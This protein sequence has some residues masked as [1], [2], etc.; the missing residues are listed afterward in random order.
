MASSGYLLFYFYSK[1]LTLHPRTEVDSS[2]VEIG[3]KHCSNRGLRQ[4]SKNGMANSI[5]SNETAHNDLH[6]L[7]KNVLVCMAFWKG[8]FSKG[9]NLLFLGANYVLLE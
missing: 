5:N 4:K 3:Q 2:I 1:S 9:K 6:C 8:I 7:K